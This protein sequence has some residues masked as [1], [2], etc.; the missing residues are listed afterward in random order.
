MKNNTPSPYV[1]A[2]GPLALLIAVTHE[3]ARLYFLTL[4][5]L[6]AAWFAWPV[7]RRRWRSR[8]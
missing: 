7:L 1:T 2:I 5:A 4:A 6:M 3:P 8:R